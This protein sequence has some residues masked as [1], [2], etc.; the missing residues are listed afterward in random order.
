ML[1]SSFKCSFIEFWKCFIFISIMNKI[2]SIKLI[3]LEFSGS[4]EE[5]LDAAAEFRKFGSDDGQK[6][7]NDLDEFQCHRFLEKRGE[8]LTVKDLRE[9][10]IKE[11][12]LDQNNR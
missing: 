4:F 2:F 3:K 12:D 10:I 1:H 11:I 7:I 5:I 8:T 9:K 6:E